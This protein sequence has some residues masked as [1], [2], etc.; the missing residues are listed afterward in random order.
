MFPTMAIPSRPFLIVHSH[1]SSV[2][3]A[4]QLQLLILAT[5]G[6]ATAD[7]YSNTPEPKPSAIGIRPSREWIGID[8]LWSSFEISSQNVSLLVST[9]LS[10][11]WVVETTGC[12]QL[13]AC[14]ESRG[15]VFSI[16]SAA[17]NGVNSWQPLGAFASG[18][19]EPSLMAPNLDYG[20]ATITFPLVD[21]SRSSQDRSYFSF[22]PR[23]SDGP[24][25]A[26]APPTQLQVDRSLVGGFNDTTFYNG[27]IGVGGL[28]G[29]FNNRPIS[30]LIRQLAESMGSIPSHSYGYTA[31]AS[32]RG[33]HGVPASL[34]LG[35]YDMSRIAFN[36]S[37]KDNTKPITFNLNPV[38]YQP[39]L[40]L[41]SIT[42]NAPP[43]NSSVAA[44]SWAQNVP[45]NS[46][47]AL[48]TNVTDP[49]SSLAIVDS[50]TPFLWMPQDACGRFASTIGLVWNKEL[51]LYQFASPALYNDYLSGQGVSLTFNMS[52]RGN[53]GADDIV[54]LTVSSAAFALNASYPY[55]PTMKP[56]DPP[57]PYFPLQCLPLNGNTTVNTRI[58]LGR[59]VLQEVYMIV[60]YDASHFSLHQARFPNFNGTKP[61]G[62]VHLIDI[63]RSPTSPYPLYKGGPES[64]N[65]L[66]SRNGLTPAATAGIVVGS[67][68]AGT[69][70]ALGLWL[71][72]R[73][74]QQEK[75][76]RVAGTAAPGSGDD[77][78]NGRTSG[79]RG[80]DGTESTTETEPSTPISGS[81]MERIFSFIGRGRWASKRTREAFAADRVASA[82][83]TSSRGSEG[84]P[85]KD[86]IEVAGSFSH[87]VEV[88]ADA[89][90]A[91]YELPVPLPPVELD[92]TAGGI[93]PSGRNGAAN[94]N[95][96]ID[97]ALIGGGVIDDFD[98]GHGYCDYDDAT[99]VLGS[100]GV[101]HLTAYE[102]ARRRMQRQ[103]RGPVPTYEPPTDPAILRNMASDGEEEKTEGDDSSIAHNR[104]PLSM[105]TRAPP[106]SV[107]AVSSRTGSDN[108][109]VTSPTAMSTSTGSNHSGS[110]GMLPSPMTPSSGGWPGRS[111]NGSGAR[112]A[113]GS[114]SG[115]GTFDLPSPMT[116]A[117]PFPS[118]FFPGDGSVSDD[119]PPDNV[120]AQRLPPRMTIDPARVVC[121]GPLPEDVLAPVA[122]RTSQPVRLAPTSTSPPQN[123]LSSS[124]ESPLVSA[125]ASASVS[126]PT[127]TDI[128]STLGT[129]YTLEEEKRLRALKSEIEEGKVAAVASVEAETTAAI[130]TI[131]SVGTPPAERIDAGFDLVH[132]PQLAARRYSWEG[133]DDEGDEQQL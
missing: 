97:D 4:F 124:S 15:G 121:L 10:E 69:I 108:T 41:R 125:S 67:F 33:E 28:D 19:E 111:I 123:N 23:S 47:T 87:P 32:Y 75:R 113:S 43:S 8:G 40:V 103:L 46:S 62:Y 20:L 81:P 55:A 94:R 122:A 86:A 127:A 109:A 66:D 36:R 64:T 42:A 93:T 114:S 58:V 79:G 115:N 130:G 106:R 63:P 76:R 100:D 101:Q 52:G 50:T 53:T 61:E 37:S 13:P 31:G 17:A 44:S 34:T 107:S 118:M 49:A 35:G 91:R 71:Y 73:R 90:H 48:L 116:M 77:N 112:S 2:T 5:A 27:F 65:N 56:S 85:E 26:P 126:S 70:V 104:A 131:D 98:D 99:A 132:V 105:T 45:G 9:A 120:P 14:R 22:E 57:V 12:V 59:A 110:L 74:R 1:L 129:N 72:R 6:I 7:S 3:L 30:P 84:D 21:T 119:E 16:E 54:S 25:P 102:V 128:E 133:Q 78:G 11:S 92:A 88:G 83:P 39:E 51:L 82:S 89:Q 117:A 18:L 38:H 80:K 24:L 95:H 96:K 29:S 60:N 68:A